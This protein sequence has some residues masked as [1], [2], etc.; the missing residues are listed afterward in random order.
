[1][2]A[3]LI[4]LSIS[5]FAIAQLMPGFKLKKP[6]TAIMVAVVYSIVNFFLGWLLMAL[7][8]PFMVL[9]LGLFTFVINALLLWIT[10]KILDD[11]EID[12]I[13]TTLIA[14]VGITVINGVLNWIF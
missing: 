10:D 6:Y 11:F 9:T 7:A 14:A 5:I 2:I 13:K 12:S 1:M 8:L 3:K 4:I